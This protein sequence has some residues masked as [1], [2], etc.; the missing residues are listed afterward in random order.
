MFIFCYVQTIAEFID[1]LRE[2]YSQLKV[3]IKR[4]M[5]HTPFD[6]TLKLRWL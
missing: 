3:G 5:S 4:G 1:P 2:N 6:P